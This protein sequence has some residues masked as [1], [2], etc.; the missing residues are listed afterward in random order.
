MKAHGSGFSLLEDRFLFWT[1]QIFYILFLSVLLGDL[2][3]EFV[4]LISIVKMYCYIVYGMPFVFDICRGCRCPLLI[5]DIK[6]LTF[7]LFLKI[8]LVRV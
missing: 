6:N 5:T 1:S 8:T 3:E 2:F 7:P 4:Y